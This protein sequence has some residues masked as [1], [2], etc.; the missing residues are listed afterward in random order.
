MARVSKHRIAGRY[1]TWTLFLRDGVYYADGRHNAPNVGKHSLGT[2]EREE[3]ERQLHRLD[4]RKAVEF[5][6]AAPVPD[7]AAGERISINEGWQRYLSHV[8]RPSVLDGAGPKTQQRYQAVRDKHVAYCSRRGLEHWG[9][10]DKSALK[11]YVAWLSS[12]GYAD[13]TV[14]TEG[15]LIKQVVI[16][17]IDEEKALPESARIRLKLSRSEESDTFCYSRVQVQSMVDLCRADRGLHWLAD[18]IIALATTGMRVGEMAALCWSDIDLER[19][20]ITI[21]DNRHSG[22]AKKAGAIRTTKGRRTRR[23]DIH[24]RLREVLMKL[25]NRLEGGR[26]FRGRQGGPLD[27]DKVLKVLQRDVIGPLKN[28]FPTPAGE[29]GF[30]HGVVHGFRHYFVTEAFLGGATEGEVQDWVGH[31]DS[32]IVKRYRHLRPEAARQTMARLTF[33]N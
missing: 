4:A 33:L 26:V 9:Q 25:P 17:L 23:V 15:T 19:G 27:P 2:T 32:R 20:V 6:L 14:Y 29:I 21:A 5:G 1:F 28:Q 18:V 13:N 24:V 10:I 22:R 30:Q 11:A 12:N 31:R 8:A 16:W 3:A 7:T